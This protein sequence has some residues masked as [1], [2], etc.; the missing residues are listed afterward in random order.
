[1]CIVVFKKL[2]KTR[3]HYLK[4]TY[5]ERKKFFKGYS[6]QDTWYLLLVFLK[7]ISYFYFIAL[8]LIISTL[9][10]S[11]FTNSS[12]LYIMI[13][14]W[15]CG[16]RNSNSIRGVLKSNSEIIYSYLFINV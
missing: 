5:K 16:F 8:Y 7:L 2:L 3:L 9:S 12:T 1:M 15:F 4:N 14:K 11:S 13:L 10:R 6:F